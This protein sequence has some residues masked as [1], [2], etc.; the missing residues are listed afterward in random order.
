MSTTPQ[1]LQN[2]SRYKENERKQDRD[3]NGKR[4][5]ERDRVR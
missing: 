4:M 1:H 5:K 2:A 3:R